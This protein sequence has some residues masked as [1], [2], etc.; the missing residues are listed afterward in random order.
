MNEYPAIPNVAMIK[1]D[2]AAVSE[3]TDPFVDF[4]EYS[5]NSKKIDRS[6]PAYYQRKLP[7][8]VDRCYMRRR[9]AE[10]ILEAAES[11]P[12]GMCFRIYDAWRP[13]QVQEDLFNNYMDRL[14]VLPENHGITKEQL[15]E[16]TTQFV[17]FPSRDCDRPYAHSTGGAVDLTI[18][19]ED[20]RE[21]N[22]GT[23]F[24]DFTD[25][26]NTAYYEDCRMDRQDE[27]EAVAIRDNRRLLYYTMTSA[28][29]TNLPSEWWHYDY[30]DRFWSSYSKKPALY[31]GVLFCE[32]L[33]LNK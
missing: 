27:E 7:G 18:V 15:H 20:G 28:G 11:L 24:D 33:F 10:L 16:L 6:V 30:G 26:A 25:K 4:Y 22:M 19:Y 3:V 5:K 29:F 14:S 1:A 9:V 8:A 23:E 2:E 13:Y 21:L 12:Q 17:S 32:E 31:K